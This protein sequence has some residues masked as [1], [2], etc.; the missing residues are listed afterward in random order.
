MPWTAQR[1]KKVPSVIFDRF[2]TYHFLVLTSFTHLR[3]FLFTFLS[4]I[5]DFSFATKQQLTSVTYWSIV[6][7]AIFSCMAPKELIVRPNWLL[8]PACSTWNISKPNQ[9]IF[10]HKHTHHIK[11]NSISLLLLIH[12]L[13][14]D[15]GLG[16]KYKIC[17]EKTI[18]NEASKAYRKSHYNLGKNK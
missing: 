15:R 7:R 2:C 13:N 10:V 8:L 1:I 4:V 6:M 18:G 16:V 11:Y 9:V 3:N 5:L 14:F 17:W 12:L